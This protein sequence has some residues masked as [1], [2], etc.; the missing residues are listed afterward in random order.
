M[1]KFFEESGP[2]FAVCMRGY[3]RHQVDEFATRLYRNIKTSE[4]QF[5]DAQTV[6]EAAE[7]RLRRAE[8]RIAA[9]ERNVSDRASQIAEQE[10]PTLAGLGTRVERILRAA[11]KD[12][13]VQREDAKRQTAVM[14]TEARSDAE[15]M[16][17]S[18]HVE[19]AATTAATE[20]DIVEIRARAVN[21]TTE[22]R[23]NSLRT[24]D[25]ACTDAKREAQTVQGQA[26]AEAE[27]RRSAADREIAVLRATAEREV[28]EVKAI[29]SREADEQR[30]AAQRLIA[31]AVEHRKKRTQDLTLAEADSRERAQKEEVDRHQQAIAMAQRIVAEAEERLALAEERC[32]TAENR[33]IERCEE[34]DRQAKDT[35]QRSSERARVIKSEAEAEVA[36]LRRS[37][38]EQAAERVQPLAEEVETLQRQRDSVGSNLGD[39]RR[40]LGM[41]S[42]DEDVKSSFEVGP[43]PINRQRGPSDMDST[44]QLPIVH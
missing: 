7:G 39:L 24:H 9:L 27:K 16:V 30:T 17:R 10:Q 36:R 22:L 42:G 4:K 23:E 37:A 13:A 32:R 25:L 40:Q 8:E 6:L 29:A 3:D 15:S 20:Q 43:I 38:I 19:A 11:E 44:Q 34:A 21:E 2:E 26:R 5:A 12:A 41:V 28:T 33:A 31:E 1:S 35:L 14:V 18:A